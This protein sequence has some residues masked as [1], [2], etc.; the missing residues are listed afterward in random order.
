MLGVGKTQGAAVLGKTAI[1]A[2]GAAAQQGAAVGKTAVLSVGAAGGMPPCVAGAPPC[3]IART[4][5]IEGGRTVTAAK[6]TLM[7]GVEVEGGK[8]ATTGKAMTLRAT[9]LEAARVCPLLGNAKVEGA[10]TAVSAGKS[11]TAKSLATASGTAAKAAA[12]G[13]GTIWSGTGLSLGLGMGLGALGPFLLLSSLGL[14]AAGI[15]LYRRNRALDTELP[16][17]DAVM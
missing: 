6:G 3:L 8:L 11:A 4:A 15:Y 14:A 12:S 13:S 7:R 5:E 2:N 16:L 17:D 9:E 10:R 1:A